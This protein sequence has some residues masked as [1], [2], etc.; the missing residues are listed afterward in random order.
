MLP[1]SELQ[2]Q[3]FEGQAFH[4][5]PNPFADE[6]RLSYKN[7]TPAGISLYDLQGTLISQFGDH[8]MV[9]SGPFEK[10]IRLPENF[11]KGI[12]MLKIYTKSGTATSL[13]VIKN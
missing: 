13:K 3:S 4:A 10:K 5:Y 6:I 7:E 2:A 12:Y 8:D 9:A 1:G 11:S